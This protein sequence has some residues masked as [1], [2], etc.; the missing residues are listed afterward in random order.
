[1]KKEAKT[2]TTVH[3]NGKPI[4][5]IYS[6]FSGPSEE[7]GEFY[8]DHRLSVFYTAPFI[9]SPLSKAK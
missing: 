2:V 7:G 1:M 5:E 8:E 9:K 6:G 4:L 3:E